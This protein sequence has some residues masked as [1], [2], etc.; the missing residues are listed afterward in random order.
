[1]KRISMMG[2]AGVLAFALL[3]G[4]V[5]LAQIVTAPEHHRA[6]TVQ[7]WNDD[8]GR[9]QLGV[10]LSDVTADKLGE[11]KLSGEYGALVTEVEPDS[12]AAKAGVAANDVI[13]EFDGERVRSVSQLRR[14]VQDTPAGRLVAVKISRAGQTRILNVKLEPASSEEFFPN[15]M[16]PPIEIPEVHV[17][18]SNFE[19]FPVGPH[20]GIAAQE[21]NPQLAQY[22][23]VA[24]G[25]G[26]LVL[27]VTAG[28][29]AEKAGLKAG[30]CIVR[31]GDQE[32][33]SVSALHRALGRNSGSDEKRE[34]SLTIVRDRHEQKLSVQLDTS[35]HMMSSPR[36]IAGDEWLGINPEEFIRM[37]TQLQTSAIALRTAQ[38]AMETQRRSLLREK[39]Q[40]LN[41]LKRERQRRV[42]ESSSWAVD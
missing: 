22:F 29:A 3:G 14:L 31:V 17:P 20:L 24:Q 19:I 41:Q 26:V 38:R 36:R 34:V 27:E 11:L 8:G 25:K 37:K 40:I 39:Q 6:R 7:V 35:R 23:G 16:M 1:M 10:R 32:V 12:P 2:S 42:L 28:S 4:S 5:V 33:E 15:V 30:D 18:D 13:L 21:L 9:A